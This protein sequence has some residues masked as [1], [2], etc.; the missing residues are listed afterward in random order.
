MGKRK[1]KRV[2]EVKMLS[3]AKLV[4][5]EVAKEMDGNA[6]AAGAK[7]ILAAA[8]A[9][10]DERLKLTKE[11]YIN[12]VGFIMGQVL[13][14]TGQRSG[15]VKNMKIDEYN[16]REQN[17]D[18]VVVLVLDHKTGH[19]A[20]APVTLNLVLENLVSMYIEKIRGGM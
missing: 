5:A 14:N 13:L 19:M 6:K 10:G 11:S 4:T 20:P 18:F 8:A 2:Q 1:R 16:A 9:S 7:A 12:V 3:K 17:R 15:A